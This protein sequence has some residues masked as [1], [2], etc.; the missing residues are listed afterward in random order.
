[1]KKRKFKFVLNLYK[2]NSDSI[3][4]KNYEE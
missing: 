3:L 2:N 4:N 1:M